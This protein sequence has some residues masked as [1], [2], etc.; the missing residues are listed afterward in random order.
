[1]KSIAI[2]T[3]SSIKYNKQNTVGDIIKENLIRVFGDQIVINNYYINALNNDNIIKEDLIIAMTI[4]RAIKI[5]KFVKYPDNIIVAQR[6]YL[7]NNAQ[8]LFEI[9]ND[10]DILVV[11]DDIE[12]TLNSVSSLYDIGIKHLNLIPYEEGKEYKHIK[13]AISPSELGV[14][15]EP[16]NIEFFMD[17]GN[18][19]LD[20]S[21]MML[22]MNMLGIN[23]K[24]IQHN[25]YDY[26]QEIFSTN[27]GIQENYNNLLSRTQ[28]LDTLLDLSNDGIVLT[29]TKGKIL[30]FNQKFRDIFEIQEPF[31]GKYLHEIIKDV[32][33]ES[34]YHD[35][36][37]EDL[38]C[39]HNKFITL[40]KQNIVHF[41]NKNKLYFTFQEVTY[42]KKLEQNITKTLRQKGQVAKYTF[43]DIINNSN[44]IKD[45]IEVSKKIANS[46]LSI[47]I[48]GET[49]TGKEVL[50]QSIHNASS[51][52]HQPFVAINCA[53]MPENLLESE[54][55]GYVKGSFTGA[56]KSGKK[57]LFEIANNGTV[58]LDEIGDMPYHLQSKL[59][60]VL[61]EKQIT[62]IGSEQVIDVDVR[63]I[64]ATHRNLMDMIDENLFRK[65]LFYR[66]NM[67][68]IHIPPLRERLED[69]VILLNSFAKK[70]FTFSKECLDLFYNYNWPGNIRELKNISSYI[71]AIE[72][73]NHITLNSLPNYLLESNLGKD[74]S[75]S[76]NN[77]YRKEIEFLNEKTDY[78]LAIKVL[79]SIKYLNEIEKTAGRKHML[80]LLERE[81][82]DI[83]ESQLR[84]IIYLLNS[85]D[86]II[87]KGGRR[88]NYITQ[89]GKKFLSVENFK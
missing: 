70:E 77:A 46:D 65:D 19:V 50:S 34:Y 42:I 89:K 73:G 86:L 13:L 76:T 4:S 84:K 82:V 79:N 55:F 28:I 69:I 62:P 67:F 26:Y 54:L 47:L 44:S 1:M 80:D 11:N 14:I 6:T 18:R 58:F 20:I 2:V 75:Q 8:P 35:H 52:H 60:R 33:F 27:V 66:L 32:D 24:T 9:P 51:R 36:I 71:S 17:I 87:I 5:R 31:S 49:G 37:N 53:A 3:D 12:T 41:D 45:V 30:I 22:I 21:T 10:T 43:K 38:I 72:K 57:G 48:T 7:K 88:G 63:I 25:L 39:Y 83:A 85:L 29:T 23:N 15:P 59:I 61:Q 74:K 40:N 16:N 56:L 64:S 68:P 78:I 81:K